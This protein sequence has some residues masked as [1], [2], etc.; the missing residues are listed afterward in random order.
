MTFDDNGRPEF[1]E[2][3]PENCHRFQDDIRIVTLDKQRSEVHVITTASTNSAT[4]Q[5]FD[6]Q[7]FQELNLEL[8]KQ[9]TAQE[10]SKE[11]Q[12]KKELQTDGWIAIPGQRMEEEEEAI[13]FIQTH[14]NKPPKVDTREEDTCL[15]PEGLGHEELSW[16]SCIFH[17]CGLHLGEK[18]HH[19][20]FPMR[21]GQHSITR[22]YLE[23][24]TQRVVT[25]PR[26]TYAILR[27]DLAYPREC[28]QDQEWS[29]CL[30]DECLVHATRKA[31]A[32]REIKQAYQG[33]QTRFLLPSG[34]NDQA[35]KKARRAIP[36]PR[37]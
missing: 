18:L 4:T 29:Q 24:E 3:T 10:Q 28:L 37:G 27:P 32:W 15:I 9:M 19:Q 31:K 16:V 26:E 22:L 5:E 30:K 25:T 34:G 11:L 13:D 8:F 2:T 7:H 36:A 33:K 21:N 23:H 20:W 1:P 14:M 12:G 35:N 6:A 17:D